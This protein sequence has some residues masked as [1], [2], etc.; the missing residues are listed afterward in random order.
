MSANTLSPRPHAQ[1]APLR[2]PVSRRAVLGI[3]AGL[4]GVLLGGCG[5]PLPLT[6]QP[7]PATPAAAAGQARLQE[8]AAVH[9]LAAYRELRDINIGYDGQW[10]PLI[11]RIQP[12]VV[13]KA[14]RGNSQERLMPGLGINAQAYRGAAGSKHVCWQRAMP[15]RPGRSATPAE[16]AVWF[17]GQR[18]SDAAVGAAAAV[19]AEGYGLFLL[20]PLWLADRQL[21]AELAGTERVNGRLCDVVNVWLSPGLGQV[22]QDRVALCVDRDDGVTRRVRFTL[23]G[24]ASTQGAVAEVDTFEHQRRFG[25]LWPMRSYEEVVHPLRVPAHDWYVTGLDVNRGY[26]PQALQGPAFS[27]AAAPPASAL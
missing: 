3:G 6:A 2:H 17:N 18:S 27:G 11:D 19:V 12:V 5:T 14:F 13:D 26:V 21:P 20:G 23:E 10:R 22:A 8:S 1:P 24:F 25:V 16:V 4:G 9:G 7:A 15:A